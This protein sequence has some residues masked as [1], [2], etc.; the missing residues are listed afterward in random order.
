MNS[1]TTTPAIVEPNSILEHNIARK[2]WTRDEAHTL[3]DLGFP[4]VESLELIN[5]DLLVKTKSRPHIIWQNRIQTWLETIFG[6]K[7]VETVA[8][9]DVA[10]DDNRI[11]QPEPDLIV[12]V[13][14]L[15]DY[16]SRLGPDEIRL[17]IEI[18]NASLYVDHE[19]KS[20]DLRA[21]IHY[22]PLG[23]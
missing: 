9:I 19:C 15:D 2:V 17:L 1:P 12:T 14:T 10:F 7:Y 13:K 3:L 8:P 16:T 4:G 20:T 21:R 11:N 6:K 23:C 22:R 5:G 18:A